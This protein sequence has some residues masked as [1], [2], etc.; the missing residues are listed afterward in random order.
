[1][2]PDKL[3]LA[4][5]VGVQVVDEHHTLQVDNKQAWQLLDAESTQHLR[6]YDFPLKLC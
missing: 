3:A 4:R 1:M 2:L 5:L 6:H